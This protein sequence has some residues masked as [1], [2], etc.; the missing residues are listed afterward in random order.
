MKKISFEKAR[1]AMQQ[2][3]GLYVEDEDY[4]QLNDYIYCK[5][6]FV[7]HTIDGMTIRDFLNKHDIQISY[8]TVMSRIYAGWD[9]KDA[10]LTPR[11]EPNPMYE[12]TTKRTA[13][14]H[15]TKRGIIKQGHKKESAITSSGDMYS[16]K[17]IAHFHTK[18]TGFEE[19]RDSDNDL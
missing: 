15:G 9:A 14:M 6:R 19:H 12:S 16:M 3:I 7:R 10:C 17:N 18:E 8:K 1:V 4:K 2:G 13:M 5:N 11:C